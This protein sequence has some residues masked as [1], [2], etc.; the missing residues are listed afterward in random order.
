[1]NKHQI[2]SKKNIIFFCTGIFLSCLF[3][4]WTFIVRKDVLHQFDFNM[5]VHLQDS[6]PIRL[7]PYFSFLSLIG[8][9][10]IIAPVLFIILLLRRKIWGIFFSF[11]L[12][13]FAHIVEIIGK[14]FL[15]QPPP[16]FMFHRYALGFLFPSSYVQ[17][18]SSYPSGHSLRITF[19]AVI[20]TYIVFK[21]KKFPPIVKIMLLGVIVLITFLMLVSR[22]S[23]GEHWTTDVIGGSMLGTSFG[24]ISLIFL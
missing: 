21:T 24:L 12:F 6:I 13:G 3:F 17:P 20:C 11:F 10:E 5:T 15:Y 14:A 23:L 4:V 8:S 19:L 7:D 18:G 2:F 1:M 9:V 22:V 16:P